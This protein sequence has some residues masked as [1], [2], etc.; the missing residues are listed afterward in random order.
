MNERMISE[1]EE[2]TTK[3]QIVTD[4]DKVSR[5]AKQLLN[6]KA[7]RIKSKV[8]ERINLSRTIHKE[9]G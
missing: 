4:H 5:S 3:V 6:L 7:I 1:R 8:I 2:L 9:K